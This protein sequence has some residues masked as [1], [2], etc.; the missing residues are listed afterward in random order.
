M[1]KGY[2]DITI[3]LDRSGSMS[4]L[5]DD[6]I[7]GYNSYVKKQAEV[8]GIA[9]ISLI[10]FDDKYE[11]NYIA[12]DAKNVAEIDDITYRPRGATALIDAIGRTIVAMGER[13]SAMSEEERPEKV[14]LLIQTD[15]DENASHEYTE[16]KINEMITEQESKYSWEV[17]FLGAKINAK[18]VAS[19]LGINLAKSMK[20]ADNSE[21]TRSAFD[22]VANNTVMFRCGMKSDMTYGSADYAAQESAGTVQ[23]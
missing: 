19:H 13:F 1:K 9:K 6:V 22:A 3:I 7:G 10:Q 11:V 23:S 14:I 20:F 4:N 21:G 15:G 17:V 12:I 8:D 2:C 18:G 5:K 16:E